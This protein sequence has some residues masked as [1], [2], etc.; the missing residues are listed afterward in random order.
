[1]PC[2][3]PHLAVLRTAVIVGFI[4]GFFST[5]MHSQ[6][7]V[8]VGPRF[9]ISDAEFPTV[10]A[11]S[12]PTCAISPNHILVAWHAMSGNQIGWALN[13]RATNSWTEGVIQGETSA[14][15]KLVYDSASDR[16]VLIGNAPGSSN[17]AVV[18]D[19]NASPPG[20][21]SSASV[22]LPTLT[23]IPDN[24]DLSVRRGAPAPELNAAVFRGSAGGGP[25]PVLFSRSLDGGI[26]WSPES[27]QPFVGTQGMDWKSKFA[28]SITSAADNTIAVSRVSPVGSVVYYAFGL[29][30]GVYDPASGRPI[31]EPLL[32]AVGNEVRVFPQPNETNYAV[33]TE[34]C[35]SHKTYPQLQFD[36]SQPTPSLYLFYTDE[37]SHGSGDAGVYYNKLN[38][39]GST[40]VL[41]PR[42]EVSEDPIGSPK[43]DQV[44]FAS[45][46]DDEGRFF[47][48]YYEEC[49]ECNSGGVGLKA[50]AMLAWSFDGGATVQRESLDPAGQC[51]LDCSIST[52]HIREY[53]ALSGLNGLVFA[54]YVGVEDDPLGFMEES[55]IYGNFIRVF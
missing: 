8:Y 4:A 37:S 9:K 31:I 14:D 39:S 17:R 32:D 7:Q 11:A 35:G 24:P 54:A 19:P 22:F 26:T 21:I 52:A 41:G 10:S 23:E 45:L 6:S 27:V 53:S 1:M 25:G 38:P 46:V 44:H 51:S 28:V 33:Y 15:N 48:G 20:P 49:K 30:A 47:V 3:I 55:V 18:F 36:T 40:W 16:F 42:M 29:H 34:I 12:E 50:R 13:D 43:V 5:L 2:S